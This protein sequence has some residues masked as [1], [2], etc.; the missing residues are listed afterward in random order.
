V[1]YLLSIYLWGSIFGASFFYACSQFRR[2]RINQIFEIIGVDLSV[3]WEKSQASA[4]LTI[5]KQEKPRVKTKNM[6]RDGKLR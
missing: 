5:K 3:L 1:I 4:K 2:L 6:L